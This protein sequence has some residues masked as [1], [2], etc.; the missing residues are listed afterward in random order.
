MPIRSNSATIYELLLLLGMALSAF[1]C[2]SYHNP[3]ERS[4]VQQIYMAGLPYT[5]GHP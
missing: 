5:Y 3:K 4:E 2:V 1:A